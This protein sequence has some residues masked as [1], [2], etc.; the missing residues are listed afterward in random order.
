[1]FHT[2]VIEIIKTQLVF[3]NFFLN[4]VVC[5]IM[6]KGIVKQSRPLTTIWRMRIECWITATHTHTNTNTHTHTHNIIIV[7]PPQQWVQ[8]RV[9]ILCYTYTACPVVTY[10]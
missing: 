2:K 4:H 1:M 8:E 5:E 6:R 3:N 9:S 10:A 7:L